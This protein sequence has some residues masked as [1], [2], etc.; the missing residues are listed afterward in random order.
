VAATK[1]PILTA[2]QKTTPSPRQKD[3]RTIVSADALPRRPLEESLE[4]AKIIRDTYAGKAATWEEIAKAKGVSATS[5]VNRYPLWSAV[6][7]GIVLK[8]EDNT[9]SLSE[10]G[11]KSLAPT[12]EG[13]KEKGIKKAC[14]LPRF[15]VAFTRTTTGRPFRP[16]T[17]FQMSWRRDAA[18]LVN[19]RR[20]PLSFSAQMRDLPAQSASVTMA[21]KF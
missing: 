6:A 4:V 18:F 11:R 9:Y 13:G 19:G 21:K 16:M 8:N 15:S 17:F 12:Y 2:K 5:P 20:K 7:Y 10:T 3:A 14:L 1:R